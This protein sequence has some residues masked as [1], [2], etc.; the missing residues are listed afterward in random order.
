MFIKKLRNGGGEKI[1]IRRERMGG[2]NEERSGK[3]VTI[4]KEGI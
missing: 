2:S 1:K 4:E 3:N